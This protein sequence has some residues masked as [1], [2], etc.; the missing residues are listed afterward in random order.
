MGLAFGDEVRDAVVDAHVLGGAQRLPDV[1]LGHRH[2]VAPGLEHEIAGT[3]PRLDQAVVFQ[4]AAGLQR[5]GQADMVGADQGADRGHAL[6]RRKHAVLDGAPVVIGQ[7]EIER[8][9]FHAPIMLP[10]CGWR[11]GTDAAKVHHNSK[12]IELLHRYRKPGCVAVA[13]SRAGVACQHRQEMIMNPNSSPG[14]H[15]TRLD[16][17][18]ASRTFLLRAGANIV[19]LSG[20]LL[21]DAPRLAENGAPCPLRLNA[22][23]AQG[24][25]RRRVAHHRHRRRP[26]GLPESAGLVGPSGASAAGWAGTADGVAA[27]QNRGRSRCAAQHFKMMYDSHIRRGVEQSGSSSGS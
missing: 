12:E 10:V 4:Q 1:R 23:E 17:A 11:L 22:G 24:G 18:S 9:R 26:A 13:H 16:L 25:A 19:C 2:A 7:A 27:R 20:S 21:I 15:T 8:L 5:R 6:V 14:P 3:R